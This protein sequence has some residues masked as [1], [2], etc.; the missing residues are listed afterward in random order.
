VHS[1]DIAFVMSEGLT[2]PGLSSVR[3]SV[4]WL[5]GEAKVSMANI[6]DPDSRRRG[7]LKAQLDDSLEYGAV[8]RGFAHMFREVDGKVLLYLID[9]A[10]RFQNVT[11][12]DTYF[13]WL[14]ALRELT[15]IV[16]TGMMFFIGALTRNELPN[17]LLQDEIIRRIGVANYT[18]FQN[19]SRD[20]L[21]EFLIELFATM[22]RK[23]EVPAPHSSVLPAEALSAEVPAELVA[24]TENDPHRLST[25]PFEPEAFDEFVAQ[26]AGG[27]RANKPSEA[28]IRLQ[29]ICQRAI[30]DDKRIIDVQL[31]DAIA[32]EGF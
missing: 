8:M 3:N 13:Q 29:K 22:I 26:L 23:G 1:E 5:G 11:H 4:R 12:A 27:T 18:E 25:Y 32:S 10:E 24:L 6:D 15:E 28:L 16:G 30:R 2:T 14:A 7:H 17:I 19:P 20:N 21:S 9:E 31:V